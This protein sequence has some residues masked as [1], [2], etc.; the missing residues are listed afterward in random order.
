MRVAQVLVPPC[1]S[2]VPIP[3]HLPARSIRA[4][5]GGGRNLTFPARPWRI[6]CEYSAATSLR[7]RDGDG[8]AGRRDDRTAH[9]SHPKQDPQVGTV[10]EAAAREEGELERTRFKPR[11]DDEEGWDGHGREWTRWA[12]ASSGIRRASAACDGRMQREKRKQ[13]KK[14]AEERE[15]ALES[16]QVPPPKPQPKTLENTREKDETVIRS[17]DEEI[18][19]DLAEDEFA[20]YFN[21]EVSPK[22]LLTTGR[23][24]TAVMFKFLA[25][26]LHVFPDATYYK[27]NNYEIKKMCEYASKRGFT[28]LV[29][30]NEDRKNINGMLVVHLPEGPT[31]YFRLSSLKLSKEI[32]GHG[33]PTRHRPELVL[34][35]FSTRIG[36]RVGRM[37][38]SLF[39]QDP[40]FRGRR[41]VTF[42]NQ[43]DFI[44][45]RHHRY[46]FESKGGKGKASK[47]KGMEIRARLQEL[48]PRFTLK[49]QTLQK[50]TFDSKRG[51]YEWVH[52]PDM[53][54]SRR[55][56]FL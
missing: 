4:L 19:Q 13:R 34:N 45:F 27:R 10:R 49:L 53:D 12:D 9:V 31:A 51:E 6:A 25:D 17:D 42:H 37:F 43:R 48:G 7:R 46:V 54:T 56:F 26:L 55:R 30:I 3:A 36:N 41:V 52:K 35:N 39:N 47:Q 21:R 22:V 18:G 16:G 1:S 32:K 44:F 50:G 29:V 15:K 5:Q 28:D 24:P 40:E 23:K 2:T 20:Q 14:L 38:A 11:E 8:V 33:K